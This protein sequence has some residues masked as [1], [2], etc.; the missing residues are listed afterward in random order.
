MSERTYR[1]TR[2]GVRDL[3][4]TVRPRP[5][6]RSAYCFH[7]WEHPCDCPCLDVRYLTVYGKASGPCFDVCTVCGARR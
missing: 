5:V 1:L 6:P 3:G 7:R 4:N 2:Q